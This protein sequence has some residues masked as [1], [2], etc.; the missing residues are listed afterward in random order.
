MKIYTFIADS[1][2]E[3]VTQI[4]AQL[5]PEAVVLNVRKIEANGIGKLWKKPQIEV[6][7]HLPEAPEPAADPLQ[8]LTD[9]R[10][11]ISELKQQMP[12]MAAIAPAPMVASVVSIPEAQPVVSRVD[13]G[14]WKVG[15][16][17]EQGGVL[18][19]NVQRIL[20]C[21]VEE[22]GANAPAEIGKQLDLARAAVLKI[23]SQSLVTSAATKSCLH[24]FVG[25]AGSGKTTALSKML[26]QRVLLENLS[27]RVFRLDGLRANTAESLSVYCE[28]LGVPV[29][30][31]RAEV[32]A[33]ETTF[34][35]LPGVNV[36]DAEALKA[37]ANQVAAF[38]G[39]QVH[40]VLNAAYET[41][42]LLN[43]LRAFSTLPISDII[44]THLDEEQRWGKMLN[45]CFGMRAPISYLSAGQN[46]PGELAA[47]SIEKIVSRVI[48]SK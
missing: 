36:G 46:V 6:L 4:R 12:V 28:I 33:T 29:E 20:D 42:T 18:P 17:L 16:F 41:N 38:R 10:R 14:E 23:S 39:A 9:L 30:R 27:A 47:S 35:D 45:F 7:A 13:Y 32:V 21:I 15:N 31:C 11:E 44:F 2:P 34:I 3:A 40:L 1:A 24:V 5:G 48:P 26:A 25:T 19:R 43:Q 8:A 37:L 22:H